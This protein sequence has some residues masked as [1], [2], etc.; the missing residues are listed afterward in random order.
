MRWRNS[1]LGPGQ[2]GMGS[3]ILNE[4]RDLR[5]GMEGRDGALRGEIA[6]VRE[7]VATVASGVQKSHSDVAAIRDDVDDMRVKMTEMETDI[8]SIK[9]TDT[10]EKI[11]KNS[12]WDGPKTI[13]AVVG[14]L[15]V[16]AGSITAVV[17]VW[18]ILV[19]LL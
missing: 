6:A 18:P 2:D 7:A 14:A 16:A 9:Q 10:H 19:A 4:I 15:G 5:A 1:F 13:L 11:A 3:F 17:K 12:A 8:H